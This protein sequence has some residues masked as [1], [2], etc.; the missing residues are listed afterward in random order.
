VVLIHSFAMAVRR[1]L[2]EPG[3]A[4]LDID[5]AET[6]S[7]RRALIKSKHFLWRLYGEW[8]DLIAAE[9]PPTAG[10]LL[11]IGSGGGF[12]ASA[13]PGVITSDV[14]QLSG[15]DVVLDAA[16]LPFCD[17]S[18]RGVVMTNVL[19]HLPNVRQFFSEVARCTKPGSVLVMVE[20]WVTRWSR[21]VY[22]SLHHE[23][24]D[25]EA[26]MWSRTAGKPLS[27]ANGALPWIVFERDRHQFAR[28]FPLLQLVSIRPIMPLRYLLSGGV[29]M[30]PLT[31][32]WTFA[33]WRGIDRCLIR[34]FPGT[35]MFAVIVVRRIESG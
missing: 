24:F 22:G 12:I 9:T 19:H 8:Y 28:D 4:G 31:P 10:S 3:T 35:A 26:I 5:D 7:R 18:L 32:A 23:P 33:F 29:S 1:L 13:I 16:A 17:G 2:G 6:T 21:W 30:R 14:L 11:E 34:L 20:P 25:P 15:V 27:E